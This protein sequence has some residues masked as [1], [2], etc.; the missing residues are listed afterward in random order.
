MAFF[1][2]IQNIGFLREKHILCVS[3]RILSNNQTKYS[4]ITLKK[5]KDSI[6]I[7][8]QFDVTDNLDD[9]LKNEIGRASCRERV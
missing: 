8:T 2:K 9:I 5:N 3:V 1:D 4:A 6:E 7:V